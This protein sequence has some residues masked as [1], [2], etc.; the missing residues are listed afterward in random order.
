VWGCGKLCNRPEKQRLR[1]CCLKFLIYLFLRF[2]GISYGRFMAMCCRFI[3]Q[4]MLEP[5]VIG[6][7]GL[8]GERFKW[9]NGWEQIMDAGNAV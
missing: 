5:L 6:R 3:C 2:T 7:R 1:G 8:Y 4:H 9:R